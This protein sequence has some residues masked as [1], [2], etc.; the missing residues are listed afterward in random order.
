MLMNKADQVVPKKNISGA[1]NVVFKGNDGA[2]SDA[3]KKDHIAGKRPFNNRRP[4][5]K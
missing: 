3:A 4:F 1:V 5:R 2:K